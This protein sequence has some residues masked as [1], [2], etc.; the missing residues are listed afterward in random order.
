VSSAQGAPHLAS[1]WWTLGWLMVAFILYS[2]LAPVRDVPDVHLNDKVEHGTAFFGMTFWF[3]GLV[4]RR[5]YWVVAA[6]MSA[7]GAA[8]EVAQGTMGWGRDMD[9]NDWVADTCGVLV[10]LAVLL[11][12]PRAWGSWLRR[13]E[14]LIGR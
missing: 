6:V 11:C 2:T 7:L 3:G 4:V 9:F 1:L 8:I 5:R 13:L 12:L 14:T 10:A